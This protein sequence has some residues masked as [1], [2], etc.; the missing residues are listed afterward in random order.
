[1][2]RVLLTTSL[3]AVCFST[4]ADDPTVSLQQTALVTAKDLAQIHAQTLS[5]ELVQLRLQEIAARQAV[6][7]DKE[8]LAL[9]QA[10]EKALQKDL[11]DLVLAPLEAE[12]KRDSAIYE[13]TH[14]RIMQLQKR[15]E[16]TKE[17]LSG[18]H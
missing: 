15:I 9:V 6:P 11:F 4:F 5:R 14:G 2:K 8:K 10:Q 13:P 17:L 16:A 7:F 18:I 3:L 12:L 1:M